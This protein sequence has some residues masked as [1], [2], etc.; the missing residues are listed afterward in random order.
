M[1]YHPLMINWQHKKITVI[2]GGSVA[3]RKIKSYLK[4]GAII[5]IISPVITPN[6]YQLVQ[7]K[8]IS[9]QEKTYEPTD[10]EDAL[11]IIAAT[12]NAALNEE[13]MKSCEPHQLTLNVSNHR[14]SNTMMPAIMKQ[15]NLQIAVSTNGASPIVAQKVRNQIKQLIE[16]QQLEYNIA[17]IAKKRREIIDE[18]LNEQKQQQLQLLTSDFILE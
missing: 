3:E 15:E 9:W 13:I 7:E 6:L 16:A 4:T 2:G 18:E 14:S 11:Y 12:N 1:T 17:R 5:T 8:E 10:T